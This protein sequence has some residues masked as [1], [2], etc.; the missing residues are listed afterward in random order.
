MRMTDHA[1]DWRSTFRRGIHVEFPTKTQGK[2]QLVV[3]YLRCS[4]CGQDGFSRNGGV[5]Y[6]WTKDE[7]EWER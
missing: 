5:I 6:T 4:T 3:E 7:A 1:H 2:R